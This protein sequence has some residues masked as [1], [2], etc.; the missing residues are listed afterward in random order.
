MRL[1]ELKKVI[2]GLPD[3]TEIKVRDSVSDTYRTI[4]VY[5]NN[6][7]LTFLVDDVIF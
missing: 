6:K 7:S 5:Y 1:K 4:G 2:E 3:N